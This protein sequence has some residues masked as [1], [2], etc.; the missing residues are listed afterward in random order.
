VLALGCLL[1]GCGWLLQ[2][3][4]AAAGLRYVFGDDSPKKFLT[5]GTGFSHA[6]RGEKSCYMVGCND[7]GLPP[8]RTRTWAGRSVQIAM[9][10]DEEERYFSSCLSRESPYSS[11]SLGRE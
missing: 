1:G 6:R 9:V 3:L 7:S 2:W 8:P 11:V 4:P 5:D 10:S